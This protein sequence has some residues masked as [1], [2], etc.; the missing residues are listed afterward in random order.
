MAEDETPD[1][2][3]GLDA[4][5]R[6]DQLEWAASCGRNQMASLLHSTNP[7][8][9]GALLHNPCFQEREALV[10][11]NRTDLPS[12]LIQE[13]ASLK[14]LQSSYAVKRALAKNP[15]TPPRIALEQL[16][17][18]YVFDLVTICLLPGLAA[19][20][21]KVAEEMILSQVSKLAIGQ[22]ITLARRG[23]ARIAASLLIGENLQIIKAVLDN[24]YLTER[25]LLQVLNRP[26]CT[27]KI[28]DAI[29]T[30]AKWSL[31]YD[32]RLALL[33]QPNVSMARALGLVTGLKPYD[34]KQLAQD[35]SVTPELRK[36]LARLAR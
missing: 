26:T 2:K 33:R 35:S 21:K 15:K 32:I 19:E 3:D 27:P 24:P 16:K 34:L 8:V 14:L 22:R 18:L 11:L 5:V 17:F 6:R 28:V 29:A 13:L 25:A 10:L 9:L 1:S 4:V 12:S 30:H 36:Y 20:M 31:R 7:A 23:P